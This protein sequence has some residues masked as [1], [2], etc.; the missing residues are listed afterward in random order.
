MFV[1]NEL[2]PDARVFKEAK[3]L[4]EYGYNVRVIG[5]QVEGTALYE[6]RDGFRIYR[7]AL[8]PVNHKMLRLILLPDKLV[9]KLVAAQRE[10]SLSWHSSAV[11]GRTGSGESQEPGPAD[12]PAVTPLSRL[13][14][15]LYP[16]WSAYKFIYRVL[17]HLINLLPYVYLSYL[18]YYFRSF[19]LA[20]REQADVY[21]AHDLNTLPVAWMCSRLAKGKLVYDSHELWL[22]RP[23]VPPR[24]KLNRFLVKKIESFLIR[25]TDANII[26][27]DFRARELVKRYHIIE[28]TVILNLP[29]YHP[30]ESSRLLHDALGIPTDEMIIIYIGI[31][32][33]GRGLEEAVQSLKYLNRC[34]LVLMGFAYD[35]YISSL[36]AFIASEGLTGRVHFFGP[37]PFEE[38]TRYAASAG[39]GLVLYRNICLNWYYSS[40]N[41]LF[42]CMAAGLPVVGSNFPDLKMYIEGYDIGVTCDPDNP[43]DIADGINRII[44]D[45]A[46]Y[47]S[48][49]KNALEAAKTFN[50]GNESRKLIALYEGLIGSKN[51]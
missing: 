39:V 6:G 27:G 45:E 14:K 33:L 20:R 12:V 49:R 17:V 28:P 36:E 41:K 21:T 16:L 23:R 11:D 30:V 32:N 47:D 26:A 38:V 44:S 5:F 51:V 10:K 50:W 48:M 43:R 25:R 3:T 29:P 46:R 35:D 22:D 15:F 8:D 42:E 7:V 40:P 4:V 19:R 9:G 37:V 24:S 31:V 18:D 2:N 1:F 13:Y 34:H